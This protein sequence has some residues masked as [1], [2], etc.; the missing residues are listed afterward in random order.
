M[1]ILEEVFREFNYNIRGGGEY[2]WKCY[3]DGARYVNLLLNGVACQIVFSEKTRG[4]FQVKTSRE[5]NNGEDFKGY[6]IFFQPKRQKHIQEFNTKIR[7]KNYLHAYDDKYYTEV[8]DWAYFLT[9][10]RGLIDN[11]PDEDDGEI[12]LELS[13][14]VVARLAFG[15]H[16]QNITLNEYIN[17]IL[18]KDLG[19]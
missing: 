18:E 8:F 10:M 7:E 4:V 19:K 17:Q 11:T 6:A 9:K 13:A 15:A 2:N 1:S 16:K 3:G 5:S 12:T 14:D